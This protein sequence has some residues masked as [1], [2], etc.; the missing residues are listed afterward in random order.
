MTFRTSLPESEF[1]RLPPIRYSD[2][3]LLLGSCFAENIGARL[4]NLA[5][6]LCAN[7]FGITYNPASIS[8]LLQRLAIAQPY[9]ADELFFDQ[10]RG[11]WHSY[12]HHSR[13]THAQADDTLRHINQDYAAGCRFYQE[14]NVWLI[15]LGTA[16][17]YSLQEQPSHIVNN[18][19]HQAANHFQRRRLSPEEAAQYLYSALAPALHSRPNLHVL[20]TVSPIRHL[21]DGFHDNQLSKSSLLLAIELLRL[22]LPSDRLHYFPA[23]ELLLDDLRDY[24]F[25]ADDMT[26]PASAAVDYIWQHFA[27]FCLHPDEQ[28][29]RQNIQQL[30]Q[31]ASHRPFNPQ[32]PLHQSFIEKQL[33]QINK[34][35]SQ[36]L[37]DKNT[38][39]QLKSIFEQQQR[40]IQ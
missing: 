2:K 1:P 21:K 39:L 15:T 16:W 12:D 5:Y 32:T 26:H 22:Q 3:I 11:T 18:C 4:Q 20:L 34:L 23:Y 14:A 31:A 35:L 30:Q 40:A 27:Q 8:H 9:A 24:R 38:L 19:H 10:R 37:Y 6:Q 7:P 25:F 17:V 13:F 29:A 36:N 28:N 33:H